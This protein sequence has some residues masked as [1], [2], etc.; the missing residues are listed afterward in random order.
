MWLGLQKAPR[1]DYLS[2]PMTF[3]HYQYGRNGETIHRTA[4]HRYWQA[5]TV[6]DGHLFVSGGR[7]GASYLASVFSFRVGCPP[8]WFYNVTSDACVMC[9]VGTYSD[10]A[11]NRVCKAC[12]PGLTTDDIMRSFPSDCNVCR[13]DACSGHGT[14]IVQGGSSKNTTTTNASGYSNLKRAVEERYFL[15]EC[16][17]G[18]SGSTCSDSTNV[19]ILSFSMV[20]LLCIFGGVTLFL[21][22]RRRRLKHNLALSELLLDESRGE[23]LALRRVW[24]IAADEIRLERRIDGDSPG[25]YGEVWSGTWDHTAVAIKLLASSHMAS[26]DPTVMAEFEREI[27][28]MRRTRHTN[29]VRF[30]GT[31]TMDDGTPFLVEELM[32][33]PLTVSLRGPKAIPLSPQVKSNYCVQIAAG[34]AYIHKQGHI[35]RDLKSGNV[36]LSGSTCKIADFGSIRGML[37]RGRGS[38]SFGRGS[39]NSGSL[40]SGRK[41]KQMQPRAR[42]MSELTGAV[43]TSYYMALE[44][45]DGELDYGNSVD[46]WSFAVVAWEIYAQER[47]DLPRQ[48]GMQRRGPPLSAQLKALKQGKRLPM[49]ANW[50]PI[51]CDLLQ[52]CWSTEP[53]ERPSFVEIGKV[54]N[55]IAAETTI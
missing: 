7:S 27:E 51:L 55:S 19:A 45:L 30:F 44:M 47:P 21:W 33:G 18:F 12:P 35:H 10:D 49:K 5:C 53:T 6:A 50:P 40:I 31:G 20:F 22:G 24:E 32:D 14:C 9:P 17:F 13:E 4:H 8:G 41:R 26:N 39:G 25:F 54:L 34:M 23:V 36:L 1:D 11:G 28:F 37:H 2:Q 43:G 46:V 15:C 52:D 38:V 42:A 29:I 3:S 16:D 48:L